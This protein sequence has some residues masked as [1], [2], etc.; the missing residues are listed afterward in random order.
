MITWGWCTPLL[1]VFRKAFVVLALSAYGELQNI[2]E[3]VLKNILE[4]AE[5]MLVCHSI[6][7]CKNILFVRFCN[8]STKGGAFQNLTFYT[9]ALTYC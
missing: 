6:S 7:L 5:G 2:Y 8:Q 4:G 3:V 1:T 9:R